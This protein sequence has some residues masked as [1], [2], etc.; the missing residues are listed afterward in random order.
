[1]SRTRNAAVLLA[2]VGLLA[3]AGCGNGA[4]QE[5]DNPGGA[6]IRTTAAD[7]NGLR[8]AVLDRPYALPAASL[9]DT[10]GN[11]F[12]LR[13]STK[14]PVTL[15]FFG[16][17]NCP[18]VCST[19]MADVASAL[20]KL[21]QGVRDD[22]QLLFVTTDPARDTGPVIRKYLDRFD[23]A[24]T[25]LTGSLT[26]I[27][28]IAKAVGVPVEGM[29]K[30]PSGGYEVGHGA[31]VLGFGKDDKATVLWLSNAAIGDLA[32]DFGKLVEQNR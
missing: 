17:T 4:K 6:V 10:G 31:Q 1:M 3:L 9:T 22:V 25:G 12:N 14:K 7:P 23:P 5:A 2:A 11:E 29:K 19:V 13:T 18:D 20:T 27:K 30:L 32:H 15:V 8:G 28:D 26:S 16:Y 21:D 24:F